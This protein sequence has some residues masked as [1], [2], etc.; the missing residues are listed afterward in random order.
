MPSRIDDHKR[1]GKT[2]V[3]PLNFAMGD[4]QNPVHWYPH[5]LPDYLWLILL[6]QPKVRAS[7]IAALRDT[8]HILSEL[9]KYDSSLPRFQLLSSLPNRLFYGILDP[10]LGRPELANQLALLRIVPNFPGHERWIR[11][12]PTLS[13]DTEESLTEVAFAVAESI[14]HQGDVATDIAFVIQYFYMASGK[15]VMPP[16]MLDRTVEVID[17]YVRDVK[18]P[19]RSTF[20]A[21]R[22][23]IHGQFYLQYPNRHSPWTDKFWKWGRKNTGCFESNAPPKDNLIEQEKFARDVQRE[24]ID[25]V[26]HNEQSLYRYLD[27]DSGGTLRDDQREVIAGFCFYAAS[28][29]M[30]CTL[31]SPLSAHMHILSARV[32]AEIAITAKYMLLSDDPSIWEKYKR[33]GCGKYKLF[34]LK[35]ED[36][37]RRSSITQEMQMSSIV[38]EF[39]FEEF[40]DIEL[41]S[42]FKKS[43][44]DIAIEVGLK[45]IYDSHY[46]W[47]SGFVHSE[48]GALRATSLKPCLNPLHRFHYIPAIDAPKFETSLSFV[49]EAMNALNSILEEQEIVE[50]LKQFPLFDGR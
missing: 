34:K 39:A 3:T 29:V 5:A 18:I 47:P 6:F 17:R 46:E 10:F 4:K 20:R 43:M 1:K 19:E 42:F 23:G 7:A 22:N 26:A 48:W 21:M 40:I 44:R 9:E 16:K 45:E 2:L 49:F 41:G 37:S 14:Y 28:T 30:S 25:V 35:A 8:F 27:E 38:D 24:T 12:I 36:L 32:I 11:A 13:K 50:D 33:Y 15:L 31:Q